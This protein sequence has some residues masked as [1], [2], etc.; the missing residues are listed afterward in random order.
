[1][2]RKYELTERLG[3]AVSNPNSPASKLNDFINYLA[4]NYSENE[5]GGISLEEAVFIAKKQIGESVIDRRAK[6]GIGEQDGNLFSNDNTYGAK[7]NWTVG[8]FL[9]YPRD[10]V[11]YLLVQAKQQAL[12]NGEAD[13]AS[14]FGA[15]ADRIQN[16]RHAYDTF[17]FFKG[18]RMNDMVNIERRYIGGSDAVDA[19]FNSNKAGFFDRIFRRTSRQYK[20][21]EKEFKAYREGSRIEDGMNSRDANR[22]S[23]ERTAKAYLRYKIP[24]WDGNGLPTLEQINGLRGKSKNRA[25]LCFNVLSATKDSAETEQK[26]RSLET[27]I[28]NQMAKDGT[29]VVTDKLYQANSVDPATIKGLLNDVSPIEKIVGLDGAKRTQEL[30]DKQKLFQK[31]LAKDLEDKPNG[32]DVQRLSKDAYDLELE[33]DDLNMSMDN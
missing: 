2:L 10:A 13:R 15:V 7:G 30:T 23:V 11:Q 25:L 16:S 5:N 31:S 26:L 12:R 17:S 22:D 14:R 33:H 24:G 21:F 8:F 1:M 3:T 6:E 27:T 18:N 4:D 9:R 28:E 19:A 32:V 20:D 29:N